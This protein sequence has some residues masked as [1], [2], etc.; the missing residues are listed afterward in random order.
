MTVD[1]G[2]LA[3]EAGHSNGRRARALIVEICVKKA[4]QSAH[5]RLGTIGGTLETAAGQESDIAAASPGWRD[6]C[7]S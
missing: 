1:R 7:R 5:D 2:H 3:I 4:N 6:V